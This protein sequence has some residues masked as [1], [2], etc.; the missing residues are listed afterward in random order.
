MSLFMPK[1]N[2]SYLITVQS[3]YE[4]DSNFININTTNNL[5]KDLVLFAETQQLLTTPI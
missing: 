5:H 1:F 2:M 3:C 4:Y